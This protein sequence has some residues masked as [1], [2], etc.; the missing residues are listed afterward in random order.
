MV[1]TVNKI[2]ALCTIVAQASLVL[3]L[4]YFL[5]NR[6]NQQDKIIGFFG[7][8]GTQFAFL[9]ALIAMLSS[10]FYSSIAGYEPCFLCWWQ[11]IFMYPLVFILAMAW[12]KKDHKVIN[13]VLMLGLIGVV[14]SL[15]HNYILFGGSELISCGTGASCARRY[16]FEYG[17][18]SIPTMCL[19]SYLLVLGFAFL[20]KRHNKHRALSN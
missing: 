11:R 12:I 17:Y 9:F 14:I 2:L 8:Y 19:T 18:I 5:I 10:L 1:F 7:K 6:K 3:G 13:Y 16:V 20:K 4:L 15:Y